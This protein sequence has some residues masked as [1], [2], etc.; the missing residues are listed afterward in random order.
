MRTFP[1]RTEAPPSR[2]ST[3]HAERGSA[4][5]K[6][7]GRSVI[8]HQSKI[9]FRGAS[10]APIANSRAPTR[11]PASAIHSWEAVDRARHSLSRSVVS[12]TYM[13]AST[14][15][16][17]TRQAS[18][19]QFMQEWITV[20]LLAKGTRVKQQPYRSILFCLVV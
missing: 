13:Y 7:H 10:H 19:T 12:H 5:R 16:H 1:S 9:H 14:T 20:S 6:L 15:W 8:R 11:P 3:L 18:R 4:P 2:T 17:A